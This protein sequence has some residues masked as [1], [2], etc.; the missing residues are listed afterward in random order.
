MMLKEKKI[1]ERKPAGTTADL[2]LVENGLE[3]RAVS[4]PKRKEVAKW[5]RGPEAR[6][7]TRESFLV[8]SPIWQLRF[9]CI[10]FFVDRVLS[11][12]CS[13][14]EDRTKEAPEHSGFGLVRTVYIVPVDST[15]ALVNY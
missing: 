9:K 11:L 14:G 2:Y 5:A 15:I 6:A 12:V 10:F 4:L 8:C 13:D 1:R 3:G 7:P